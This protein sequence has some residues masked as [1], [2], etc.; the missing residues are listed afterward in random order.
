[1]AST[2]RGS[3]VAKG[4]LRPQSSRGR[5]KAFT[6]CC[7]W[8]LLVMGQPYWVAASMRVGYLELCMPSADESRRRMA[9]SHARWAEGEVSEIVGV[10]SW[11]QL[12]SVKCYPSGRKLTSF[13]QYLRYC[14]KC[15]TIVFRIPGAISWVWSH[16]ASMVSSRVCLFEP[17]IHTWGGL[18]CPDHLKN[19]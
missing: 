13:H 19:K 10:W 11:K 8:T 14:H 17:A 9:K 18:H 6:G 2:T 5:P 12:K 7:L 16:I 3:S 4:R 1:M 15:D